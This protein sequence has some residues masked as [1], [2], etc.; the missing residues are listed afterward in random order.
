MRVEMSCRYIVFHRGTEDVGQPSQVLMLPRAGP[1]T[2]QSTCHVGRVIL[3]RLR[4]S[5]YTHT[6]DKITAPTAKPLLTVVLHSTVFSFEVGAF[7]I[8]LH[9]RSKMVF[10]PPTWVPELPVEPPSN[11]SIADFM[12]DERYGRC[13]VEESRAP[14]TCGLSGKRYSAAEMRDRVDLLARGI[15]QAVGWSPQ[16]GS[17]WDKIGAVFSFNTVSETIVPD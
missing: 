8:Y 1:K 13:P 16:Q 11:V 10:K 6:V 5:H 12:L 14:F 7:N 15:S 2:L 4:R 17:E 9:R 3:Q